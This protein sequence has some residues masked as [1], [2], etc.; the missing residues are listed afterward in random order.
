VGAPHDHARGVEGAYD[1]AVET[2]RRL[3]A[4][5][6]SD[7]GLAATSMESTAGQLA[8]VER[9]AGDMGVQF[10]ASVA[11]S[12]PIYFGAQEGERPR[13]EAAVGE[14][15]AMMRRQLRSPRP[16]DWAKAYYTRGLVEYVRG[17]PRM[18]PCGAGVD[19]FFLDPWG[20]VYP[21]NV[22]GLRM[23][24]VR[25]GSYEEIAGRSAEA[26]RAAVADCREQC[27]MVCTV[28]PPMRRHPLRP[29]AWI[30]GARFLGLG[31]RVDGRRTGR[32]AGA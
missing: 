22:Q 2:V 13:S 12:S 20:D 19:H 17:S 31:T 8:T 32:R 16:A 6:I 1:R 21:C 18:L 10:V 14:I 3:K 30:A 28:A 7:L 27:W 25:D 15:A 23:G 29:L 24:N 5:G 9:L 4:L 26:V 11:H